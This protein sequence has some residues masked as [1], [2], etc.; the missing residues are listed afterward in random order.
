MRALTLLALFAFGSPARADWFTVDVSDPN[1]DFQDLQVAIDSVPDGST[2]LIRGTHWSYAGF[3]LAGRNLAL[4]G[5]T[6]DAYVFSDGACD[7][8]PTLQVLGG[9]SIRLRSLKIEGSLNIEVEPASPAICVDSSTLVADQCTLLGGDADSYDLPS[10]GADACEVRR[11]YCA[12][13]SCLIEGGVGGDSWW[14]SDWDAYTGYGGCGIDAWDSTVVLKDCTV[15]GGD[16]GK[17]RFFYEFDGTGSVTTGDGGDA[18][19]GEAIYYAHS[20]FTAGIRGVAIWD[21]GDQYDGDDSEFHYGRDGQVGTNPELELPDTL[22]LWE[23]SFFIGSDAV[24]EGTGTPRGL[25]WVFYG[26][27]SMPPIDTTSGLFFMPPPY[28]IVRVRAS[29]GGSWLLES[30][31][32]FDYNLVGI[33]MYFQAFDLAA[34]QLSCLEAGVIGS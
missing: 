15:N 33:S 19:S 30:E 24:I 4:V 23:W 26:F 10:R 1:A 3:V 5:D 14:V 18:V 8:V 22:S 13:T 16:A 6:A 28:R 20:S 17:M 9:S 2:L 31:I 7:E 32:P 11:A 25:H 21:N 12:F 27:E 34:N 29:T